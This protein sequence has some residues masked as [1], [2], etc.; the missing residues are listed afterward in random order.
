MR[1]V[2]ALVLLG[3]LVA[4]KE[5]AAS[6]VTPAGADDT[7][8][9]SSSSG[10]SRKAGGPPGSDAAAYFSDDKGGLLKLD[11][12]VLSSVPF[13]RGGH[14]QV[15]K[16]AYRPGVG[17]WVLSS[18]GAEWLDHWEDG[19]LDA[20]G[21]NDRPSIRNLALG[22]E[23]AVWM[24]TDDG[25]ARWDGRAYLRERASVVGLA[26]SW[27]GSNEIAIDSRGRIW[28]ATTEALFVRDATWRKVPLPVECK[29]SLGPMRAG[30]KGD[31]LISVAGGICKTDGT[32]SHLLR[33]PKGTFEDDEVVRNLAVGPDGA[34]VVA[35]EDVG[36]VS[37]PTGGAI[38][39]RWTKAGLQNAGRVSHVDV[40]ADGRA[41]VWVENGL[42]V[43]GPDGKT[44]HYPIGSS[45]QLPLRATASTLSWARPVLPPSTPPA[46]GSVVGRLISHGKPAAGHRI[47]IC[48]KPD[49]SIVIDTTPC[50]RDVVRASAVT[51]GIGHFKVGPLPVGFVYTLAFESTP[52]V[53][54][55]NTLAGT[56][57]EADATADAGDISFDK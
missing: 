41:W 19:A 4:C 21:A 36:I 2:R 7:A 50:A 16:I 13:A 18:Q 24:T 33:Y 47:E 11:D 5:R 20:V 17:L 48:P 12:G 40:D 45:V 54:V 37:V 51:D 6:K 25:V 1:S 22:S 43:V 39:R 3:A 23:A 38:A 9:S 49:T 28:V 10:S 44:A 55:F 57:L 52:T 32:Q 27:L 26:A 46:R 42:F 15:L 56:K 14:P 35:S 8:A 30:V 31:V 34:V 53:W 29:G